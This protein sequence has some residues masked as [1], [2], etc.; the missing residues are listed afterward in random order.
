M[1]T[2]FNEFLYNQQIRLLKLYFQELET[3]KGEEGLLLVKFRDQ[4]NIDTSFYT[5][6]KFYAQNF[7]KTVVDELDERIK[8]NKDGGQLQLKE[9]QVVNT[10]NLKPFPFEPPMVILYMV[11]NYLDKWYVFDG[12]PQKFA[13]TADDED[14]D[15]K[16]YWHFVLRTKIIDDCGISDE[17]EHAIETT[18]S[19]TE[20]ADNPL[21]FYDGWTI[22]NTSQG[23]KFLRLCRNAVKD[24]EVFKGFRGDDAYAPIMIQHN[25]EYARKCVEYIAKSHLNK[26]ELWEKFREND[27]VGDPVVYDNDVSVETLRAI[28]S[29]IQIGRQFGDLNGLNIIEI[30]SAF[31]Y[32]AKTI[33][34]VYDFNSY[35]FIDMPDVTKLCQKY[36]ETID[37]SLKPRLIYSPK[38]EELK[39]QYDLLISEFALSEIDDQGLEYYFEK[40]VKRS[41]EVFLGM[42]I[43]DQNKKKFFRKKLEEIFEV[44]MEID[45][46]PKTEWK[47]YY[48]VCFENKFIA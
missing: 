22:K 27:L 44:V 30:G 36:L 34:A 2:F 43:W 29:M 15:D 28:I 25:K 12:L 8:V 26:S 4:T 21:A 38:E 9:N 6:E 33:S 18:D 40:V 20:S 3:H 31:G 23:K 24:A 39:E 1:D 14:G 16:E 48:F 5:F 19:V 45:E 11:F 10:F 42:N 32:L 7:E 17:E 37:N 13:T 46:T 41:K 47:N 35:T